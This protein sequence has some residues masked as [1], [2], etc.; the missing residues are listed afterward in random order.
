MQ[1]I[2]RVFKNLTRSLYS[3]TSSEVGT[4][5]V[6]V[7]TRTPF[8]GICSLSHLLLIGHYSRE[9]E[10]PRFV[11]AEV[12]ARSRKCLD[13][14]IRQNFPGDTTGS[15]MSF[16]DTAGIHCSLESSLRRELDLQAVM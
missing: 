15:H 16:E 2:G 14:R 7:L 4:E 11:S 5:L 12:K 6:E 8:S 1:L 3:A 13:E 9:R 10:V